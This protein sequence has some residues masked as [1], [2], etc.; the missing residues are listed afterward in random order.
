MVEKKIYGEKT[1]LAGAMDMV[2]DGGVD[3]RKMLTPR[4]QKLDIVVQDPIIM[5]NVLLK[6][7]STKEA[8]WRLRQLG[9][10]NKKEY[11]RIVRIIKKQD[12]DAVLCSQFIITFWGY[13]IP[14][15]GTVVENYTAAN[16]H[17]P[18]YCVCFAPEYVLPTWFREDIYRSGGQK[19]DDFDGLVRFLQQRKNIIEQTAL[20]K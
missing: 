10:E 1:Y 2:P 12:K 7:A 6:V 17:I 3:W 14:T 20:M 9:E 15:Y 19:F 8:R 13:N 5:T 16:K 4:L 11:F 18:I